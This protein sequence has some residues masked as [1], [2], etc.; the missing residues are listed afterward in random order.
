MPWFL[1]GFD[2]LA[3]VH[4]REGVGGGGWGGLDGVKEAAQRVFSLPC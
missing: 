4:D 2:K 3:E 1:G